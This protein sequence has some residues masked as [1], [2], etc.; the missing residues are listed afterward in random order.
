VDESI[1]RE[2]WGLLVLVDRVAQIDQKE[3]VYRDQSNRS[4]KICVYR[5]SNHNRPHIHAYWKKEYEISIA[6]KNG[7]VLA[8]EFPSKY[9]KSLEQWVVK[10]QSDLLEAWVLIQ[11]GVKPELNWAKNS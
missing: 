3:L 11:K 9:L 7:E 1:L 2:L 6:I 8:G 4:L 5:E 10:N